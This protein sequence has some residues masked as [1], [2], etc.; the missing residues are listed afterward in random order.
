MQKSAAHKNIQ[1]KKVWSE[2]S[3]NVE[4]TRADNEVEK[5]KEE[6]TKEETLMKNWEAFLVHVTLPLLS[7]IKQ[8]ITL[9]PLLMFT[10]QLLFLFVFLY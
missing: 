10:I 1:G 9:I 4:M 8:H 5:A 7:K 2:D 6:E 3:A